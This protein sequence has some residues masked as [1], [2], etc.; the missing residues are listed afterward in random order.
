MRCGSQELGTIVMPPPA[1]EKIALAGHVWVVEEVD[2]KRHLVYCEQVKGKVPA[3]FGECPGDI[4]TRVLERMRRVL[5]EEKSYPYLM[6]NAAARL[7]HARH[8]AANSG[9]TREPLICLGGEMW[10]LFPWLGSYA[11]LALERFLKLKCAPQLGLSALDPSR[12]Y[13][14]QF[15]MKAGPE[16]FFRVLAEMERQPLDPM[17]LVYPGEVPLFEKYDEYLPEEL[18]KKGFAYGILDIEGMKA[19]IRSWNKDN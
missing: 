18:V 8:T 17:E 2:H 12:P 4:H 13:F 9:L 19:R 15:K 14:I 1:G 5:D 10:C 7:L 16:E 11:F 6:K 3:Y